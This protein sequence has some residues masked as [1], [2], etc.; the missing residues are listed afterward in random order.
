MGVEYRSSIRVCY[1]RLSN[2]IQDQLSSRFEHLGKHRTLF[3]ESDDLGYCNNAELDWRTKFNLD[4]MTDDEVYFVF[5]AASG[6]EDDSEDGVKVNAESSDF[7]ET[8]DV[9]LAIGLLT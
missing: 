9:E 7:V 5:N 6:L 2:D 1:M 8:E 4:S 3:M